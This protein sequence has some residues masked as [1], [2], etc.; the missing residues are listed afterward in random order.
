[1]AAALNSL[2]A[3]A[4]PIKELIADV[5]VTAPKDVTGPKAEVVEKDSASPP[6]EAKP[7]RT[8]VRI[9]TAP[10]KTTPTQFPS[11]E[12]IIDH[13]VN[14]IGGR[15]ALEKLNSRVSV[16]TVELQTMG[17][18]G[19][20]E[21]YE[22]APNK[23]TLIINVDGMGTI[24][25]TYDGSTAWLQD[26]LDGFVKFP[27]AVAARIGSEAT[28][29]RDRRLRES[30][31]DLAVTAK[32]KIDGREVFVVRSKS[33]PSAEVWFFDVENG[34]LLRRGRTSYGDYREVD[35][36]KLPFKVTDETSYGF[37]VVV[38][39]NEIKHNVPIDQSK[40]MEIPDC[41]TRPEQSWIKK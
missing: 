15:A 31:A 36:V 41:F 2:R 13:Y 33:L 4:S 26:P 6:P 22:Q 8:I 12:Q 35:G 21:M 10:P 27:P 3:L 7:T 19:T 9:M 29:S 20:A 39:L 18:T 30:S 14:A 32:E 1:M 25:Q 28:F 11:V 5:T 34:L 38:H 40:F 17:L 37:G 16:G 23:S 24:Q